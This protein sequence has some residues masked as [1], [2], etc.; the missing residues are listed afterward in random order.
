MLL[1]DRT[2]PSA[3]GSVREGVE[4]QSCGGVMGEG[5]MGRVRWWWWGGEAVARPGTVQSSMTNDEG[6]T[7][8]QQQKK[9]KQAKMNE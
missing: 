7:K 9:K 6:K 1:V 4:G 2:L 5:G 8:K 3:H